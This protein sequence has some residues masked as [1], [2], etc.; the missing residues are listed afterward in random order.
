MGSPVLDCTQATG[1]RVRPTRV[2]SKTRVRQG[3]PNKKK[4]HRSDK[5]RF[6]GARGHYSAT[7]TK[8]MA[9]DNRDV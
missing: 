2:K 6:K 7:D 5:I 9:T 3:M 1:S 4:Q 8:V